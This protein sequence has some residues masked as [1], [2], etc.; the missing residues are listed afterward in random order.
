M[1][2]PVSVCLIVKNEENS[3]LLE[4]CLASIR[5]YVAEIVVVDTGSSDNTVEIAKRHADVVVV[6][7]G[8]NDANTGLI[9]SFAD[10]RNYA[11][12]LATQPWVMWIDSDDILDGGDKLISL[13]ADADSKRGSKALC[14]MFPYEYSYNERGECTC[15]HYRERLMTNTK[16]LTWVNPVH[17]VLIPTEEAKNDVVFLISDDVVFKHQRHRSQKPQESGRNLRILQKLV[18]ADGSKDPRQWYYLGL[19]YSNVNNF[20]KAVSWLSQYVEVSEWEDEKTMACLKLSS[21]YYSRNDIDNGLK[22]AF[23]AVATKESWG[24]GYFA[25]A[26]GFYALAMSGQGDVNRNWERCAHFANI[27]LALPPT[28]TM[29]FVNPVERDYEIHLFLNMALGKLGRTEEA[30]ASAM[31]GLA[32]R[33]DDPMLLL[34]KK[35]YEVSLAQ[36]AAVRSLRKLLELN[37]LDQDTVACIE[38]LLLKQKSLRDL[39]ETRSSS[40]TVTASTTQ[41]T[42]S[43][44]GWPQ[45]KRSANYP[46]DASENDIPVA[47]LTPHSQAWGIPGTSVLDDLPLRMTDSQLQSLVIAVWKEYMLHDEVTA[48]ER[49]LS[50][51]PYRVKHA[52]I[53]QQALNLTLG[54]TAWMDKPATLQKYN[55]PQDVGVECGIPLPYPL[56]GQSKNRS[57]LCMQRL[58]REDKILDFGC[59]DGGIVNR[60]GMDGYDVEAVDLCESSVA[61]ARKKATEFNTGVRYHVGQFKEVK[62]LL[63]KQSSHTESPCLFDVVT[64]CDTY[65]HVKDQVADIIHP[66]R[67]ALKQDGRMIVV[68]PHGS[69]MRGEYVPWAHPWRWAQD[70]GA[71]WN[72]PL[73]RAHLVAPT[74]WTVTDNFRKDGWWVKD[75][76]VKLSDPF[77]VPGQGNI[78]CEAYVNKQFDCKTKK[79]DIVIACGD[80][81]EEWNPVTVAAK[82]IGGSENAVIEMSKRLASRGHRV[83]VYTSCGANGEGVY[84]GVE[85]R[86]SDKM[87]VVGKCDVFVAWRHANLLELSN[88]DAKVKYLWVHDVF[89]LS[90]KHSNLLKADGILALSDWHADNIAR[91]HNVPRSQIVKTRNGIDN[92]RFSKFKNVRRDPHK[93]VYSSSPDRGLPALLMMWPKIRANVPDATLHI[94]YGF[95]NWKKLAESNNDLAQLECIRNIESHMHA[96]S[97]LGVTFRDRVS[98][99]ELAKEFLSAGVWAYSTWFSETSCQLKGTLV[100]TSEGTKKIEDIKVGDLVLTHKGRFRKVTELIR[101]Q[102]SGQLFNIKRKKDFNPIVLTAEHPLYVKTFHKRSDSKGNRVFN[103]KNEKTQWKI[104]Q[105]LEACRD[106]LFTPKMKFGDRKTVNLTDFIDLKSIDGVVSVNHAN[107]HFKVAKNELQ[108]TNETMFILG[109][110]AADGCAARVHSRDV[111]GVISFAFNA[112][113]HELI[114]RVRHFFDGKGKLSK[115][116]PNGMT[117]VI[118]S[119]PMSRFLYET[120]GVGRNK[121]IPSFVWETSKEQQAA[122]V[123]GMFAGDGYVATVK[124]GKSVDGHMFKSYTSI[125]PS[126]AYGLSQ[127]LVN[128]GFYSNVMYDASRDA[129]TLNWSERKTHNS[130]IETE[131]GFST[132][133]TDVT[134]EHY[135]GEVFNFE[136]EEDRSYVTDRTVVHNCISA[137]EAQAA[138]LRIVTSPIAALKETVGERGKMIEGDWLSDSYQ[139]EFVKHVVDAM[140]RHSDDDRENLMRYAEQNFSWDGVSDQW[141][142]MFLD[143]LDSIDA[144]PIVSYIPS[145]TFERTEAAE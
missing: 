105:D 33:P 31:Q 51:A 63:S 22:W 47:Q 93:V 71:A 117:Y 92:S 52:A 102:Y 142:S 28:K 36:N 77:D 87:S 66:A 91:V 140:T 116:S 95:G 19:E 26:R 17:E 141:E 133:I 123:D 85:Y 25:L 134:S 7:N 113:H 103:V 138:G 144:Y 34:N 68:T 30:L 101:K 43:H 143:K 15:R 55:E 111:P 39:V 27:G 96:L 78:V 6:Y 135:E 13:I 42:S 74:V 58:S 124:N 100:F 98:Q 5:P 62:R 14:Y 76:Y 69:W 108:L 56:Q 67:Q 120:I 37:D 41:S 119:G 107:P 65:E 9:Q 112:A 127:L 86:T 88:V 64:C 109:L 94:Y 75:C 45:Y 57:D 46:M 89:A 59:F 90:A 72:A 23:K 99:E 131:D 50:D 122:F 24:D 118:S 61:L 84:D 104:P 49:F 40:A 79:L 83:R 35:I 3:P 60:W 73:E 44:D 8:C 128:Q 21:M 139:D 80:T 16:S 132:M 145:P 126:L 4:E 12:S 32:S 1:Q 29:L 10:A 130:H 97:E 129:Y 81:I 20:D 53:T 136:V 48:A 115:T 54:T 125:S 18:E 70:N 2:A 38:Q 11:F 110:F 114:E 121:K 82:G 106:Y 137:M